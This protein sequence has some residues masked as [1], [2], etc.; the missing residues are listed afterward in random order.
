MHV[1]V[2]RPSDPSQGAV[3][4]AAAGAVIY[5]LAGIASL[6][7][8]ALVERVLPADAQPQAGAISLSIRNGLHQ[9]AWGGLAAAVSMP[10]G[11]RLVA[12]LR[13]GPT[14]WLVL[15]I[16]L[17]LAGITM[18][19]LNEYDQSR[20]GMFDPDHVGFA[21]FAAPAVLAIALATWATLATPGRHARMLAGTMLLATFALV[22]ALVPSVP[23]AVSGVRVESIPLAVAFLADLGSAVLAAML[24]VRRV[25]EPTS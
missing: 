10:L 12:G 23:G 9:V 25:A 14:A 6:L 5:V 22:L 1:V 13:F 7:A 24:V 11:R 21:F 3:L 18:F 17:T 8:F 2:A 20:N 16:G 15:A 4:W 19:L